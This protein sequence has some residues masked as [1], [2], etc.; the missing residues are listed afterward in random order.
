GYDLALLAALYGHGVVL[1]RDPYGRAFR[2]KL[3]LRSVAQSIA[4]PQAFHVVAKPGPR[5]PP[6]ERLA[7]RILDLSAG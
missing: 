7:K 4:N 3:G 1:A 2:E 5:H 6:A